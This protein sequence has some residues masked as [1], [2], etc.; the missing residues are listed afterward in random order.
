MAMFLTVTKN[1]AN[2]LFS[3]SV[4]KFFR[5]RCL[6]RPI[7]KNKENT[8]RMRSNSSK[9]VYS[10][11]QDKDCICSYIKIRTSHSQTIRIKETR[12]IK[13]AGRKLTMLDVIAQ[14]IK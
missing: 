1:M 5:R 8:I 4:G 6:V 2:Q 3:C 7:T 13:K 9:A 10:L 11:Q 14:E 12:L